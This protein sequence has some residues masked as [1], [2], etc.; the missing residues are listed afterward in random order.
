M[1]LSVLS[2]LARINVDPWEE[3]ARLAAMPQAI[4]VATLV[5]ALKLV[6]VTSW[7]ASETEVIAARLVQL[8]PYGS[9]QGPIASTTARIGAQPTRFWWVWVGFAVAMSLL[10][11][12]RAT[13]P[14]P[15]VSTAK[16]SET[17]PINNGSVNS[18]TPGEIGQSH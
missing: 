18:T 12:H 6:A 14:E 4:A 3:A 8:L 10:S 2:A 5:S 16:S 11:P 7:N 9:E 13:T 15:G 17:A 1:R